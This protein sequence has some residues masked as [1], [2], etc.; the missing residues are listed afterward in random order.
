MGAN[1]VGLLGKLT[2]IFGKGALFASRSGLVERA[3]NWIGTKYARSREPRPDLEDEIVDAGF[4][5][6]PYG[7]AGLEIAGKDFRSAFASFPGP[8]LVLNWQWD[9][10]VRL[11]E[12]SHAEAGDARAV[13]VDGAGNKT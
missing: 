5:L 1:P 8:A 12:R 2:R 3:T 11:G 6:T 4:D 10:L 7:E 9:L 13:V